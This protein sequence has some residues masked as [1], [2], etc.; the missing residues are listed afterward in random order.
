MVLNAGSALSS[1]CEEA[2]SEHVSSSA[3]TTVTEDSHS[4]HCT[5]SG[6]PMSVEGPVEVLAVGELTTLDQLPRPP[7]AVHQPQSPRPATVK[8]CS[9]LKGAAAVACAVRMEA[10]F[11][12]LTI[13]KQ[14]RNANQ[15]AKRILKRQVQ[16]ATICP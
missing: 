2:V 14:S 4:A 13:A 9:R 7:E 3:S 10:E 12:V 5:K 11:E 15:Q 16:A 8:D 1:C 6:E